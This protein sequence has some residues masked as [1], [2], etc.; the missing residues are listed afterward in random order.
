MDGLGRPRAMSPGLGS[1][2]RR[3]SCEKK[4][5]KRTLVPGLW[6]GG[7][8][9]TCRPSQTGPPR[10]WGS[11]TRGPRP[12]GVDSPAMGPA[13]GLPARGPGFA[14]C[15]PRRGRAYMPAPRP[16]PSARGRGTRKTWKTPYKS[17]SPS[18]G[19][20]EGL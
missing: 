17:P 9:L 6:A 5:R 18:W 1:P 8:R 12:G 16:P 19:L 20:G 3:G 11:E 10:G 14:G 15:A 7:G 4:R 2:G 13:R